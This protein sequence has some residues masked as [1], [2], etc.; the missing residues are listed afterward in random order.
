[1]EQ[2]ED[3]FTCRKFNRIHYPYILT[4]K[5]PKTYASIKKKWEFREKAWNTREKS[6]HRY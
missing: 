6:I 2:N 1:M 3:I 5:F 4:E